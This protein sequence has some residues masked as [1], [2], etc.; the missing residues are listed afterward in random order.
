[1]RLSMSKERLLGIIDAIAGL[2]T[3]TEHTFLF[4][5]KP[6]DPETCQWG[7]EVEASYIC[8]LLLHT[9]RPDYVQMAVDIID[10]MVYKTYHFAPTVVCRM[11][12]WQGDLLPQRCHE[13]L[14]KYL[15]AVRHEFLGSE[16]DFIGVNDNFPLM[17]TYTAS[18]F[19]KLYGDAEMRDNAY[20]RFDQLERLLKR[21]GCLSEY[22]SISYT[23][24][25]LFVVAALE[26]IAPDARCSRIAREVQ[27]R[28]WCDFL[29]HYHPESG[30]FSGPFSRH[31]IK[32]GR[33]VLPLM[34]EL[35][36]VNDILVGD[37]IRPWDHGAGIGTW[38]HLSEDYECPEVAYRL[39][40]DKKY[41]FEFTA[42]S[43]YTASTD[44]TPEAARRAMTVEEDCY[45]YG[46][47][48]S[49]L[50][51]YQTE[52]YGVGTATN[53]WHNGVQTTSFFVNYRRKDRL[54]QKSD[55]RYVY[56]RYLL[57]DE[58]NEDQAFMDQGRKMAFGRENQAL[59]L[60]KPKVAAIP[61]VYGDTPADLALNYKRQE[62]SGNLGVTS[63]KL[64]VHLPL[65]GV[66]PDRVMLGDEVL[67]NCEGRSDTPKSVYIQ[68]GGMY[69]AFHPTEIDNLGRDCAMTVRIRED[70]L[71]I[72]FYNY[73]GKVKDF[74]RRHF[75]HVRNGFL[76]SA[77]SVEECGSFENFLA[78]EAKTV[79]TDRMITSNHA[80]QTFIRQVDAKT[81]QRKLSCEY[82]P[83]SES[84]KFIACDDYALEFP[85]LAITDVDI[86]KL[87]L[88]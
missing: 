62:I 48:V 33:P 52:R 85:K 88:M 11:L 73:A 6:Y 70:E 78:R 16:L 74:A 7:E 21:R 30:S 41:P 8:S 1:M 68:D 26:K 77:G 53:E 10:R 17:S 22:C 5:G 20:R 71:E 86:T 35:F 31:Y 82:A 2:L 56:C 60:Y 47:G 72:A 19:W 65:D 49:G 34:R 28:I 14:R 54:L 45:E 64:V 44:A 67:E 3:I 66:K 57:N 25:Q 51:L 81:A 18:A 12:I 15:Y 9:G 75:L 46:A 38:Y 50:Y 40:T 32:S 4:R 39:V 42:T 13:K 43:E 84:I 23:S 37:K 55:T 58:T 80:R 63:A 27:A 87:P 36:P 79:I 59:V 29:S 24:L 76:F 69:L 61:A 83:A